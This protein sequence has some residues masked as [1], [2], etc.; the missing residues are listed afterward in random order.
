MDAFDRLQRARAGD[1]L[2]VEWLLTSIERWIDDGSPRPLE[3]YLALPTTVA[4]RRRFRRDAWLRRAAAEIAAD[5]PWT[6]AGALKVEMTSFL[7]RGGWLAWRNDDA[8]PPGTS[9]L[10]TALFHVAR[11]NDGED[12][13]QRQIFDIARGAFPKKSRA[14]DPTLDPSTPPADQDHEAD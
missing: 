13:S 5:G 11:L 12:L 4:A 14:A 7:T 6:G 10:R 2:S 3:T 8:P 1:P 9:R